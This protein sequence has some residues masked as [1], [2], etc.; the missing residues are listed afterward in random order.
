MPIAITAALSPQIVASIRDQIDRTTTP[1]H[2]ALP[3]Q[4]RLNLDTRNP[5]IWHLVITETDG[6]IAAYAQAKVS[7]ASVELQMLDDLW[8]PR[9]E[10]LLAQADLSSRSLTMWK[11]GVVGNVTV[12]E[13]FHIDRALRFLHRSL[14]ADPIHPTSYVLRS[15]IVGR[16]EDSWLDL[17][18][19][20]FAAHPDQ[21]A[22]SIDDLERRIDSSW[23]DPSLFLVLADGNDLI[24]F[25]WVKIEPQHPQRGE[26][27]VIGVDPKVAGRGIGRFLVTSGLDAMTRRGAREAVLYVE[28]DNLAALQLY[29]TLGFQE[30]SRDYRLIRNH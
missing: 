15:F 14:P 11:H 16:D 29:K 18:A 4:A 19:K 22:W 7:D 12:P 10:Q 2:E 17:N 25:C 13:G 21:G 20:I 6:A 5:G 23:F 1:D 8:D 28:N 9:F 30:L 27:F 26:I 24:G 3:E